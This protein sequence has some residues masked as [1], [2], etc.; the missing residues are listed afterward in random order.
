MTLGLSIGG[1][2]VPARVAPCADAGGLFK[3]LGVAYGVN[4]KVCN[5]LV[6]TVGLQDLFDFVHLFA[7]Y[8]SIGDLVL[9]VGL[10]EA[11]VP[12]QTARL[13]RAWQAVRDTA[14]DAAKLKAKR[15]ED[16]DLDAPLP[17]P[18]LDRLREVFWRRYKVQWPVHL[19]PADALLSRVAR[20]FSS[21]LLTIRPVAKSHSQLHQAT[22]GEKDSKGSPGEE[23]GSVQRYLLALR[24]LMNAYSIAGA[25]PLSSSS[26]KA[27]IQTSAASDFVVLPMDSA[28]NYYYRA[29]L[30]AILMLEKFPHLALKWL[31]EQDVAERAEWVQA[32]RTSQLT[33][34]EA[35]EKVF[36]ERAPSWR[37]PDAPAPAPPLQ[38]NAPRVQP[39]QAPKMQPPKGA[40]PRTDKGGGKKRP[41]T[42]VFRTVKAMLNG[43]AICEDF[44]LGKCPTAECPKGAAH[45]C[46]RECKRGRAC[47]MSNHKSSDCKN[48]TRSL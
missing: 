30:K 27:E 2:N 21:R 34:G 15:D 26:G 32:V 16:V 45:V 1:V 29:E 42:E 3:E 31:T 43:K 39:P 40:P 5:Y 38:N 14:D 36:R 9:K 25:T 33:V 22:A 7:D 17:K 11:E 4:D 18:E 20:E 8:K 24:V 44:N 48:R 28:F 6:G 47:G 35:V 10:G 12:L 19:A 46:N 41:A 37:I 13:R 23:V